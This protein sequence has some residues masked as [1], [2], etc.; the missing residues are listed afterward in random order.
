MGGLHPTIPGKPRSRDV[1]GLAGPA[2]A[3]YAAGRMSV[4]N[5]LTADFDLLRRAVRAAGAIAQ[6]YFADG[7]ESW[8][9]HPG[10]PVSEADLAVNDYLRDELDRS[11]PDYGW[12][13]EESRD[14]PARLDA[15]RVW[16][17]D[18]IDGTRAFLRGRPEFSI[19]VALLEEGRP[20][21][22]AVYSPATDQF[23]AARRDGGLTVNGRTAHMTRRK[24]VAG[25]HL[26]VSRSETQK[27]HWQTVFGDCTVTPIS[28]VA[29]KLA[30]VAA[31][32]ADATIS[33]WPKSDWDIA[34]GDLL[35]Q[36]GGG[37]VTTPDGV[38]LRYN[39][40]KPRHPG[41]IAANPD[42]A[43]ALAARVSRL[44]AAKT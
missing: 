15:D 3:R 17:V 38:D 5:D 35:V 14:S 28:S 21:L 30:L 20:I 1:N 10:H 23:F 44:A 26:L 13:S 33:L 19:S 36:E 2:A 18:P 9:K 11:R 29:L 6:Q 8:D 27:K 22:G 32:E 34:A 7:T 43:E 25:A 41:L 4:R 37:R 39:L 16:V 24:N 12:L 31:G 42:L 40:E